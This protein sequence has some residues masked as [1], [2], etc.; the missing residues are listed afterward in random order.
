[1]NANK[2]H[3]H[4]LIQF[5]TTWVIKIISVQ[6]DWIFYDNKYFV[7]AQFTENCNRCWWIYPGLK[8][9]HHLSS[10][11]LIIKMMQVQGEAYIYA[12]IY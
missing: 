7:Y 4:N 8:N 2:K 10:N 6:L 1:M 3:A 9:V 5:Q 11:L 12:P